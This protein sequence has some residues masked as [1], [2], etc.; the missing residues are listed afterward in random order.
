MRSVRAAFGSWRSILLALASVVSVAAGAGAQA[1]FGGRFRRL[2]PNV[3]Y[4]G[5]F[6][7]C[8][9]VFRQNPYGDG[10]GWSVDYPRAD[11]NLSYRLSELTTT[12]VSRDGEGR[13]NHTAFP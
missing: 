6:R 9:I 8:R 1:G 4:D 7:F 10:N 2:E 3:P 13:Y 12:S 5:A 11:I